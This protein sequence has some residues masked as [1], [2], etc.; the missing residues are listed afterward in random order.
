ME[1]LSFEHN[2]QK[3]APRES[4]KEERSPYLM[5]EIPLEFSYSFP[6]GE[7]FKASQDDK[8]VAK[9]TIE[10]N[11]QIIFDVAD[12]LPQ[13]WKLVTPWYLKR[14]MPEKFQEFHRFRKDWS[15]DLREHIII[16]GTSESP[17]DFFVLLHEIG[18][19]RTMLPSDEEDREKI[20]EKAFKFFSK[21]EKTERLY[22]LRELIK[23]DSRRERN[24]WAW[25][26]RTFRELQRRK[27]I[28]FKN[29]FPT[30]NDARQFIDSCLASHRW[31]AEIRYNVHL[32]RGIQPNAE[33]P[34]QIPPQFFIEEK[35]KLIELL[36]GSFD[37]FRR[38]GS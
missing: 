6:G 20:V 26:L 8:G 37:K 3:G 7:K 15:A 31:G 23:I 34:L 17:K 18:H 11:D 29:I 9:I 10:R 28:D 2:P 1:N 14:S 5:G 33:M 25:A 16:V 19:A 27:N 12:I 22:L 35:R 30:R 32:S 38:P 13:E 4:K 36:L 21:I 24:A